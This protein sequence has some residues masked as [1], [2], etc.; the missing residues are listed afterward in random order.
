MQDRRFRYTPQAV[1]DKAV[2]K[3]AYPPQPVVFLDRRPEH[4][5]APFKEPPISFSVNGVPGAYISHIM[6]GKA[7]VDGSNDTIFAHLK[8]SRIN[9]LQD[10]PG[11]PASPPMR[12]SIVM[13]SEKRPI[14]RQ[15]LA[16]E[17][18]L[19]IYTMIGACRADVID[20]KRLRL[21]AVNLYGTN[22]VPILAMDGA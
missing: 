3:Y 2:P 20:T 21:V 17:V 1:L 14:T 16:K 18:A 7:P 5:G 11:F 4:C 12:M 10:L 6:T 13:G 9:L 19:R 22:W 15:E 8:W